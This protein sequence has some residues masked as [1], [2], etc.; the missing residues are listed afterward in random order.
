[1]TPLESL[2]L[3]KK[4][5]DDGIEHKYIDIDFASELLRLLAIIE[6]ALKDYEHMQD[7]HY[8]IVGKREGGISEKKR[9]I[10][11]LQALQIIKEKVVLID[12]LFESETL[13]DYNDFK[14]KKEQ[15]TQEE[16]DLLKKT[17]K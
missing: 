16:F 3:V 17:F 8:V 1:M 12:V 15:L 5:I 13:Q 11:K 10:K 2:E 9:I 6:T 7:I 4:D 14:K